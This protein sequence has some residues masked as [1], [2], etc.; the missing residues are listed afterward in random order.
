MFR[1]LYMPVFVLLMS[2]VLVLSGCN[3]KKEPKEALSSAAVNAMKME[4]YTVSNQIK[5]LNLTVDEAASEENP[6]VGAVLSML[7]DA[8]INVNQ[9]Y[10]KDPMQTEATLEVKL[11]GD[12]AMTITI[13]FVVTTEKVYFKIPSIPFLPMPES[14]VGKFLEIDLKELAEE[15]GEEFDPEMFNTEKTQ[16]L[17]A[18]LSAAILEEYD[19]A[20]YFKSV[21]AKDVK[22]PEGFKEKQIVQFYITNDNVKEAITIFIN[23]AL[24]KA[25]DIINKE[26]YRSMLQ[27]TSEDIEDLKKD[28][29]EG[30]Q[31]ELGKALDELKN[32][33]TINQFTV[34]SAIDSKNYPS[35]SEVNA[36][37]EVNDPESD[38][39]VKLAFQVTSTFSKINEK[40]EFVIGIPTD[41]ITMD[42]LENEMGTLGY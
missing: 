17:S 15:N 2:V 6:Q 18:E 11:A 14:I 27:L 4:S 31:A 35:Y 40:P 8:E 13:P 10:Q 24:P 28:L 29:K 25:L 41:T 23:N 38:V 33:L 7:K 37:V 16:K 36:D 30:D 21:E 5:I 1:K 26:E 9:V 3:T 19:S 20:K 32:Y 34:N 39:N 22:L 42:E 12:M